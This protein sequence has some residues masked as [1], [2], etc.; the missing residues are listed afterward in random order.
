MLFNLLQ[1]LEFIP[2][3]VYVLKSFSK[4][5]LHE[6]MSVILRVC[7]I[8]QERTIIFDHGCQPGT[9]MQYLSFI[10]FCFIILC[11]KQN[12]S[13]VNVVFLFFFS[14]ASL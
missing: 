3:T 6:W 5:F 2:Q 8:L 11:G 14:E 9:P 10:L 12:T 7:F 13:L 4:C 1:L